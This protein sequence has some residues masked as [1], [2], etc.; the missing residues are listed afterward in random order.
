MNTPKVKL[1]AVSFWTEDRKAEAKKLYIDED[2]SSSVV[3]AHIGTTRNAVIGII[4]RMGLKKDNPNKKG[5]KGPPKPRVYKRARTAAE[6]V[7]RRSESPLPQIIRGE[8]I[9]PLLASV[10]G[11]N[12]KTC[13]YPYGI[14]DYQFCGRPRAHGSFCEQHGAICYNEPRIPIYKPIS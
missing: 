9:P 4:N 8:D 11:L 14:R 10:L 5:V 6:K 3:A 1:K 2:K 7:Q 13:A 12:E